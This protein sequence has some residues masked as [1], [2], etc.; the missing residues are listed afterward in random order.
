M[1]IAIWT[2][3]AL[4]L[5]LWTLLAW[6]VASLLGLDPAWVGELRPWLDKIPGAAWLSDYVPGWHAL[7]LA[8]INL[9]QAVLAWIGS[10]AGFV[11][12]GLWALGALLLLAAGGLLSLIV[13]LMGKLPKPAAQN[14]HPAR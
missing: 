8:L 14:A 5:A 11:V 2:V 12:W 1:H 7:A 3:T 13:K 6:G 4:A 9:T 10:G